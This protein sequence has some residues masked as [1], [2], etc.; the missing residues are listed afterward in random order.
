MS[1][2]VAYLAQ[3]PMSVSK[4]GVLCIG[5]CLSMQRKGGNGC[6]VKVPKSHPSHP[7]NQIQFK[8]KPLSIV[9]NIKSIIEI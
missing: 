8:I 3:Q 2:V 7:G 1:D 6:H 5:N 9:K 4:G